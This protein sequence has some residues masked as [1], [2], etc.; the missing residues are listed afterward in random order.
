M[1][2]MLPLL[3]L[4][5]VSRSSLAAP[6]TLSVRLINEAGCTAALLAPCTGA[7]LVAASCSGRDA[8]P[9]GIAHRILVFPP[10]LA[11]L[12]GLVAGRI[13]PWPLVFQDVL[14]AVAATLTPLAKARASSSRHPR[15]RR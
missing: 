11:V 5:L 3:L 13:G 4:L 2:S 7:T 8:Q 14:S 12:A 1:W 9:S 10:F 6:L 15:P